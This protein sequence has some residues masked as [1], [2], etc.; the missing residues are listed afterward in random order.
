[1]IVFS[2]VISGN[3]EG[4]F[5]YLFTLSEDSKLIPPPN[6]TWLMSVKMI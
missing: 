3:T 4:S 6:K 1:M 2:G 5:R